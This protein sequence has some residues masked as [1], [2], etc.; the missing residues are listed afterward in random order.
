[1]LRLIKP[2]WHPHLTFTYILNLSAGKIFSI[3]CVADNAVP[4]LAGA[5]YSQV[6]NATLESYPPAIFWVTIATQAALFACIVY[7]NGIITPPI[8]CAK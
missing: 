3:L 5:V 6:Y 7:V 1:M 8:L 2:G 4:I